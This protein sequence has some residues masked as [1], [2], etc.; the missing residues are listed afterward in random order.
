MIMDAYNQPAVEVVPMQ[1]PC[2]LAAKYWSILKHCF[3]GLC[4]NDNMNGNKTVHGMKLKGNLHFLWVFNNF[5]LI[6][7]LDYGKQH[8]KN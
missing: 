5:A 8:H 1:D 3:T 4:H 2:V 6:N 7:T